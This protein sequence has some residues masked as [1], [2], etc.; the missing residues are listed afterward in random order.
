[1]NDVTL[2]VIRLMGPVYLMIGLGFLLNQEYYKKIYKGIKDEP[3]VLMMTGAAAMV[4]GILIVTHHNVWTTAPEALVSVIGWI[5]LVKGAVIL[6]APKHIVKIAKFEVEKGIIRYG[7][8]L[9]TVF[10]FWL[11]WLGFF[12]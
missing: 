6:L 3:F 8:C 12:G 2:L 4:V 5:A 1:M 11:C 10:G 9:I 7:G